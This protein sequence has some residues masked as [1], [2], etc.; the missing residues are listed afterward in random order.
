MPNAL[1]DTVGA[2]AIGRN[3][4]ALKT[5]G[6]A[7]VKHRAPGAAEFFRALDKEGCPIMW[8]FRLRNGQDEK[9][10]D[11]FFPNPFI[12]AD[13][14]LAATPDWDRLATWNHVRDRYIGEPDDGRDQTSKGFGGG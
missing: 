4:G 9:M 11:L 3:E 2:V 14:E 6:E 10:L 1:S 5:G 13:D 7:L 8:G 12:T